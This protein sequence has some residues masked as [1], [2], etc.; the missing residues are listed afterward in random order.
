VIRRWWADECAVLSQ[1]QNDE[2]EAE[3]QSVF[4]R[5]KERGEL[6]RNQLK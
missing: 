5:A 6:L 2:V 4:K 1:K 3:T